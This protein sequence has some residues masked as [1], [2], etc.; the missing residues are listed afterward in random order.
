M[1]QPAAWTHFVASMAEM[2][3]LRLPEI[4]SENW[5]LKR[6][7]VSSRVDDPGGRERQAWIMTADAAA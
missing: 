3:S 4:P 5:W 7:A 6:H 2:I 1:A